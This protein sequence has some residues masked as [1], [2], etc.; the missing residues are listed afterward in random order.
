[1]S[2]WDDAQKEM[3]RAVGGF[4]ATGKLKVNEP[5]EVVIKAHTKWTDTKYP[6]KDKAG[7]SLGYTWRFI[8]ADG[9][10]WDVSNANRSVLISGLHPD[11][12]EAVTPGRFRV[13]N[14]GQSVNKQPAVRVEYLGKVLVE[15]EVPF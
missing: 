8:L 3:H 11:G 13:T 7:N 2:E 12:K 14:L 15:D 4:F 10:V 9:R 6:I 1:M 5:V